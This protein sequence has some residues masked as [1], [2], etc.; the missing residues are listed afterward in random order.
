MSMS[1]LPLMLK[2]TLM[3]KSLL[4]LFL[5]SLRFL[6]SIKETGRMLEHSES[7]L[8]HKLKITLLGLLGLKE[9][10]LRLQEE[11]KI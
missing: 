8:R 10:L 2:I 5:N 6:T 9:D 7:Q 11:L 1:K 4:R 3:K